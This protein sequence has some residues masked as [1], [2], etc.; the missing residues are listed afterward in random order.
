MDTESEREHQLLC[1]ALFGQ[2]K[3]TILGGIEGKYF[4]ALLGIVSYFK[5]K[6]LNL[7]EG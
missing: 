2:A 6:L 5:R 4:L 3:I 7:T 1:S